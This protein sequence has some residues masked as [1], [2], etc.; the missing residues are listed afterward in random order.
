MVEIANNVPDG[1]SNSVTG[2]TVNA[3]ADAL[4]WPCLGVPSKTIHLKNTDAANALKYKLL[5]YAHASGLSYEEVVETTLAIG[6][7]AQIVLLYP[8][9]T[10]K[11]QVK[12]SVTNDHATYQLDYNGDD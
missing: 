5:T 7:I 9:A 4:D 11:V 3:Y 8:Y 12:S 2:T 10:V 1:L 6:D